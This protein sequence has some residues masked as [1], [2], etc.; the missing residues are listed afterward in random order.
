MK[1]YLLNDVNPTKYDQITKKHKTIINENINTAI[2]KNIQMT[3]N[4]EALKVIKN[5]IEIEKTKWPAIIDKDWLRYDLIIDEKNEL[6]EST[7]KE[8]NKDTF[9]SI[10]QSSYNGNEEAEF[11]E[12]E[13]FKLEMFIK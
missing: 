2:K 6:I 9:E 7:E 11:D 1:L 13:F 5:D 8:E 4:I 3:S 12:D 10:I